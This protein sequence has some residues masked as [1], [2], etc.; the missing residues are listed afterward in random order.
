M[1]QTATDLVAA[2]LPVLPFM[3]GAELTPEIGRVINSAKVSDHHAI[4]PTAAFAGNGFDGLPE[5]EKKL[6]SLVCCKLLC[7]VAAPQEYE[8]V[9]AAASRSPPRAK[10]F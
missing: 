6:M 7:A 8:T 2:L 9:T 4:I 3:Q 10:R 1:A 5:S